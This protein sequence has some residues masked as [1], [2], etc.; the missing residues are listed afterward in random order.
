MFAETLILSY[1]S[2]NFSFVGQILPKYSP[3]VVAVRCIA[4]A[5][6]L[7]IVNHSDDPAHWAQLRPTRLFRFECKHNVCIWFKPHF[8]FE[9]WKS[10]QRERQSIFSSY[11]QIFEVQVACRAL[12]Q[13][14]ANNSPLNICPFAS[15][16]QCWTSTYLQNFLDLQ[17][18][19]CPVSPSQIYK[20]VY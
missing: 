2:S 9:S 12:V 7:S 16:L 19:L 1:R 17:K 18:C 11:I 14:W 15:S 13:T 20:M 10:Q 8:V 4:K 5:I 3:W 6:I